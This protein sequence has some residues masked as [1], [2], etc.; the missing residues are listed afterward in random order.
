MKMKMKM[1]TSDLS[2]CSLYDGDYSGSARAWL[3][4]IGMRSFDRPH[5]A[6]IIVFNG[7]AD[8]GTRLYNELPRYTSA[9]VEPSKRDNF[10]AEVFHT[11]PSVFKIGICRGSQL[12]NCLNGGTLWQDVNNHCNDHFIK[13]TRTGDCLVATSTHHQ[14]MRPGPLGTVI[15]TADVSTQKRSQHDEWHS[16]AG[17]FFPDDHRDTEIVWYPHTRSLCIQGHPEYV[18]GERFS[19]YCLSLINEFYFQLTEQEKETYEEA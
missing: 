11:F 10:E 18:V 8:I 14:M 19:D 13:D 15:A 16:T 2:F 5:D 9:N 7:G 6:D 1:K 17:V 4:S 12:L 3:Q